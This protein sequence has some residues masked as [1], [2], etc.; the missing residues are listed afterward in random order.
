MTKKEPT[1][2]KPS[3]IAEGT[4]KPP[5]YFLTLEEMIEMDERRIEEE[6]RKNQQPNLKL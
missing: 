2:E 6:Y 4:N 1:P 3:K 5:C